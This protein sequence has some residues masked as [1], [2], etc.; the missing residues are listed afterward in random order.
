[1]PLSTHVGRAYRAHCLAECRRDEDRC[2]EHGH[3]AG[4]KHL[5]DLGEGPDVARPDSALIT[6]QVKTAGVSGDRHVCQAKASALPR[7]S[8][9]LGSGDPA[10]PVSVLNEIENH[11]WEFASLKTVSRPNLNIRPE[12]SVLDQILNQGR[13]KAVGGDDADSGALPW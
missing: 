3:L 2:I 8:V 1:M 12:R 7:R 13:L 10:A 6:D 11:R 5:P 9:G 4:L